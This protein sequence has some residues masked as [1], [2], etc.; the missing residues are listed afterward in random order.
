MIRSDIIIVIVLVSM[1]LS[2]GIW[3]LWWQLPKRQMDQLALKIRDPKARA[4]VEDNLR[5][6]IGQALGGA[7]V[8]IAAG[9]ALFQFLQQ[10]RAAHDL[11]ISNQVSK[12]FEQFASKE[13]VMRLGGI[14]ALEGVM[15]GSEQ[16]RVP[17]L[18]ALC[19]FVRDNTVQ[20]KPDRR[21]KLATDIQAA[22][23]VI[24]RR[25]KGLGVPDLHNARIPNAKLSRADLEGANLNG[26]KLGSAELEYAKLHIADLTGADLTGASLIQADLSDAYLHGADLTDAKLMGAD[27]THADLGSGPFST[28]ANLTR[29]NLNG[30]ELRGADLPSANL[31]GASLRDADLTYANLTG[32]NLTGADLTSLSEPPKD[33]QVTQAQLNAAC[34]KNAKLPAGLILKPCTETQSKAPQ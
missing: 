2:Y 19:A 9:S 14:Y 16:Y 29:A 5:K 11:L 7:A 10:Q 25:T 26:A 12:G 21:P 27:L 33:V 15:N 18:E 20:E 3:W 31:T 23:T 22:L 34:G 4:D 13:L 30:A 6:T 32:A 28:A 8:L 1:A 17:V 24:G